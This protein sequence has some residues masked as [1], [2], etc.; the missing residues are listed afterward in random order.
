MP[1]MV[2]NFW[3]KFMYNY[4]TTLSGDALLAP[5]LSATTNSVR[6]YG[7]WV[8]GMNIY[9]VWDLCGLSFWSLWETSCLISLGNFFMQSLNLIWFSGYTCLRPCLFLE[10][11]RC[12]LRVLV[13]FN[14]MTIVPLWLILLRICIGP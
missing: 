1:E 5:F 4:K 8:V 7:S 12:I 11:C 13:A 14:K 10:F 2:G 9:N 6:A 3:C